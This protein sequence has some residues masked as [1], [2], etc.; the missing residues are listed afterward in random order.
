MALPG[1]SSASIHQ[2]ISQLVRNP[3]SRLQY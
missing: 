2:T 3:L 1:T